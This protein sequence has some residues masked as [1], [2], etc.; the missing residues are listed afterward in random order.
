M[1]I[2]ERCYRILLLLY[3]AA[4]RAEYGYWMVQA[5]RDQ[6]RDAFREHGVAGLFAI[7]LHTLIDTLIT[8]FQ[9][10]RSAMFKFPSRRGGLVMLL[11]GVLVLLSTATQAT[12]FIPVRERWRYEG[13]ANAGGLLAILALPCVIF[14]AIYLRQRGADRIRPWG[15]L[16]LSVSAGIGGVALGLVGV[17]WL[18]GEIDG[19]W[20]TMTFCVLLQFLALALFGFGNLRWR[21]PPRGNVMPALIGLALPVAALVHV[22]FLRIPTTQRA[23]DTSRLVFF[24]A[25]LVTGTALGLLGLALN[26]EAHQQANA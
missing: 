26:A 14:T 9:E 24:I 11:G 4:H 13:V 17:L 8:A 15:R 23:L 6:C 21:A 19:L 7:G 25:F 5:F 16:A 22:L 1:T 2:A 18:P 3:P 12:V 20:D 10:R